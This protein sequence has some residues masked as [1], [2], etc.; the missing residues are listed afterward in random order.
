[1]AYFC[2]VALLLLMLLLLTGRHAQMAIIFGMDNK[3]PEQ[4]W[5]L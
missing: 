5:Y 3:K 4:K 1:M 2:D